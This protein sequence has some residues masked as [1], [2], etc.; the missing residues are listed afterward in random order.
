MVHDCNAIWYAVLRT[1]SY[2]R[3]RYYDPAIGRFISE[4]PIQRGGAQFFYANNSPSN[5]IDSS[6]LSAN[7]PNMTAVAN[8]IQNLINLLPKD[9]DCLSWLCSK[10]EDDHGNNNPKPLDFLNQLLQFTAYG[11]APIMPTP[12]S[13][14]T[15]GM[16]NGETG[17][18]AGQAVTINSLGA[19]FNSSYTSSSGKT[20]PLSTNHGRIPG[21]TNA[22]LG[23]ILLHELAHNTGVIA[24]DFGDDKAGQNNNNLI[25][26]H[27]KTLIH[28]LGK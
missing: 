8:A 5:W 4:D 28:L 7:D 20:Y 26:K 15:I 14:S 22:A 3:A 25:Q 12:N 11:V 23:F 21:G 6:G 10:P 17:A 9:P 27:C 18:I 1:D 2:Y 13:D 19:G 24:H 16:I